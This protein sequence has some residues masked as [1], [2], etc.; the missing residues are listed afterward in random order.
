MSAKTTLAVV[1]PAYNEEKRLLGTLVNLRQASERP[2][3]PWQ[4]TR[5]LVVDDGS[6]DATAQVVR[7][8]AKS[9]QGL[10]PFELEVLSFRMN[11]G[12]GAAV[13]AGLSYLRWMNCEG[14]LMADADEA[15]PWS[16]LWS[17][18][19][20]VSDRPDLFLIFGSR[21]HMNSRIE[22]R[23]VWWRER[24]G[25]TFNTLLRGVTGVPYRDTQ[26][27]FKYFHRSEALDQILRQWTVARFAWDA[28]VIINCLRLKL[29]IQE[30]PIR[31]RHV[32]ASRVHPVRDGIQMAKEILLLRLKQRFPGLKKLCSK[33]K[34]E[35]SDSFL[36]LVKSQI[37]SSTIDIESGDRREQNSSR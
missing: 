27:G 19:N 31:W 22:T 32:D 16:E 4:L 34:Q 5:V 26:C 9:W 20:V 1:I 18:A 7:T 11:Q 35:H 37:I 33:N 28:E 8:L 17:L 13:F 15:T 25:R 29:P 2:D 24:L 21:Q 10:V 30:L 6:K 23:Q 14:I 36:G 12:K 3:F